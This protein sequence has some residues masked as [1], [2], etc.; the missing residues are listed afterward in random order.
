MSESS[1]PTRNLFAFSDAPPAEPLRLSSLPPFLRV[2]L[3]TDGT[4]TRTLEAYFGEPIDVRVLSHAEVTSERSY[5]A[6]DILPGHT[7]LRRRV[8]LQGAHTR[9]V[10]GFAE[11]VMSVARLPQG[12]ERK[13]MEERKGI[14]ELIHEERLQTYRELLRVRRAKAGA[15]ARDL[16][17]DE[18]SSVVTRNYII[19]LEGR[20]AMEIE[21]VFPEHVFN[22]V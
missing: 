18:S 4:V 5:P 21:E 19:C 16:A 3:V 17:L 9:V 14:G 2:L 15:W 13:L 20:A 12:M 1:V 10:Y 22:G 6:V 11:S 7:I 8:I